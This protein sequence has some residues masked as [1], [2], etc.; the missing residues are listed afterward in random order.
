MAPLLFF[1]ICFWA[2]CP[3]RFHFREGA[4]EGLLK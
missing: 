3:G 4:I 2:I 1:G